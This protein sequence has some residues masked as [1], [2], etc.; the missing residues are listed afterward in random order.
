MPLQRRR[1]EALANEAQQAAAAPHGVVP[2][3]QLPLRIGA[4]AAAT[5]GT[6]GAKSARKL[7]VRAAH[8]AQEL[9]VHVEAAGSER[10]A[11]GPRAVRARQK[12][13]KVRAPPPRACIAK[14][15]A[16]LVAQPNAPPPTQAGLAVAAAAAAAA[17]T[18]AAAA[19]KTS[20]AT[21]IAVL[22]IR[23]ARGDAAR[24]DTA[25]AAS[26]KQPVALAL[27]RDRR[28]VRVAANDSV[29]DASKTHL[30]VAD[31]IDGKARPAQQRQQSR[32]RAV[33]EEQHAPGGREAPRGC[34][35]GA[36]C[37]R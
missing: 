20:K 19:D 3:P 35:A 32:R 28:P 17:A 26:V 2:R 5:L 15:F 29:V 33:A 8:N 18:A 22:E 4:G 36:G 13:I 31:D 1:R 34:N 6:A 12:R 30:L 25:G 24:R 37:H 21:A 14:P 16:T 11:N 10:A 23:K 27:G 7:G 9:A